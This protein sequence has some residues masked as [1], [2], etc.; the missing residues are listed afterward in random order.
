MTNKKNIIFYQKSLKRATFTF[1]SNI[2]NIKKPTFSLY[3][4]WTV[5]VDKPLTRERRE[6]ESFR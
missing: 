4:R 3:Q 2:N 1:F 5:E 6:R